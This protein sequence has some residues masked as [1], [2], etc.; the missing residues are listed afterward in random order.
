MTLYYVAEQLWSKMLHPLT[1][2]YM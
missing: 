1:P 2:V